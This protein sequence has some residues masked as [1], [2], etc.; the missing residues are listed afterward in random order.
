ML[1]QPGNRCS[2]K[3]SQTAEEDLM[4]PIFVV[5]FPYWT[6]HSPITIYTVHELLNIF[7]P[8]CPCWIQCGYR[9]LGAMCLFSYHLSSLYPLWDRLVTNQLL[10]DCHN[11][12]SLILFV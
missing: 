11:L 3:L 4:S 8:F 9:K 1:V 12:K 6:A 10:K 7:F 5:F 2:H